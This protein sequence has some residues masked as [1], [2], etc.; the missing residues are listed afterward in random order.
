MRRIFISAPTD[1]GLTPPQRKIKAAIIDMVAAANLDPQLFGER[2]IPIRTSWS[3]TKAEDLMER[4]YGAVIIALARHRYIVHDAPP[5]N[6]ASEFNHYEGAL[7]KTLKRPILVI[8]EESVPDRGIT[9]RGGGEH[10]IRMP[11]GAKPAWLKTKAFKPFFDEWLSGVRGRRDIFF[12][13][14]SGAQATADAM[15]KYLQNVLKVSLM[16]WAVDFDPGPSI[17]FRVSEAAERCHSGVFL[18]TKDEAPAGAQEKATP[19]DNVVLEAGYFLHAKG[20]ERVLIVLEQGTKLP[21]DLGG[22]IYANL[23]N[24]NTIDSIH[25]PLRKFCDAALDQR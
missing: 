24:R 17:L 25:E 2:G 5:V 1:S 20:P 14:C 18:F 11:S 8:A 22:N 10:I 12:G 23:T 3:F 21:A 16:D 6:F 15:I 4:C 9:Y 19:R 13:Y 7:A